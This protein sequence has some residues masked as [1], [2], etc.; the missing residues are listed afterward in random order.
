MGEPS[1]SFDSGK[2][3]R[4]SAYEVVGRLSIR[5]SLV[6]ERVVQRTA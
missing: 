2:F 3:N 6:R 1:L 4:V 5:P